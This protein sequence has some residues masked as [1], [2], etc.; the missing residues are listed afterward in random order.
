[1]D[2]SVK[3]DSKLI[4]M[5]ESFDAERESENIAIGE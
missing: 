2:D 3:A 1:M 5:K 4:D